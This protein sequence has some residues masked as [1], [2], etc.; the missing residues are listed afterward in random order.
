M[1]VLVTGAGGYLGRVVVQE[2]LAG[3]YEPIGLVRR[4]PQEI[5]GATWRFGDVLDLP[6]LREA[7]DDVDAVIHLAAAAG[8]RT[9]FEHP[10]HVYRT[11]FVGSLNLM[12]VLEERAGDSMRVVFASTTGIYS[13]S[14]S[15]PIDE[16]AQAHPNNP[17]A[18]S[19]LAAEQA[20]AW[21]AAASKLAAL[22]LRICNI[23]GAVGSHG[24]TNDLRIVT[25]SCGVAAGRIPRL[26]VLGDGN[27]I[28]DF[29]HVVD[30]A[31]AL[32]AAI[33]ACEPGRHRA[34]NIGATPASVADVIAVTRA[35]TGRDIPITY[36]PAHYGEVREMKIDNTKARHELCW[37]PQCSDIERIVTDQWRAEQAS[38]YRAGVM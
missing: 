37:H 17:Y 15:Q 10:T 6:S 2:L 25:R 14:Y 1:R 28:R 27:A 35:V 13:S 3:G 26:E 38:H 19:K 34:I 23:A 30:V 32:V 16:D 21:Q 12:E 4:P 22:T 33:E 36:H 20:I 24:D 8:V 31:R 18:A 11:N 5:E 29:V 7:A 9:A